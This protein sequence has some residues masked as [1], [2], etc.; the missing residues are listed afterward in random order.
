MRMSSDGGRNFL[1]TK[2]PV[3]SDERRTSAQA[4]RQEDGKAGRSFS[5][6]HLLTQLYFGSTGK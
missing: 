3:R 1:S 2:D 6:R 5:L 4:D